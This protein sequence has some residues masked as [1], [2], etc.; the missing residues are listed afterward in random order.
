MKKTYAFAVKITVDE[1]DIFRKQAKTLGLTNADYFRLLIADDR[2]RKKFE[3]SQDTD[4][5]LVQ[6]ERKISSLESLVSSLI[7]SLNEHQ[8]VPSFYEFRAR[9]IVETRP[10]V[11]R[12][13]NEK[14]SLFLEIARAYHRECGIWPDP[15]DSI[16]FGPGL[17]NQQLAAWPSMPR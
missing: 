4:V 12:C 8:R 10:A 3:M 17:D 13:A 2:Q 1:A 9:K 16:A 11:P 15:S 6:M 5:S 14:F 7:S